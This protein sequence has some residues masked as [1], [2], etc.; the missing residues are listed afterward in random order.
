MALSKVPFFKCTSH[1]YKAK[2]RAIRWLH[3]NSCFKTWK[4]CVIFR[5]QKNVLWL[6]ARQPGMV[7]KKLNAI[8]K[9]DCSEI[10]E[11]DFLT[12]EHFV[13]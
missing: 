13:F 2:V 8:R 4:R 6:N 1:I 12:A 10:L 5:A 7:L 11:N 3:M 9:R